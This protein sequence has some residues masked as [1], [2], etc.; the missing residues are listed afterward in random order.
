MDSENIK[1]RV[2]KL[3]NYLHEVLTNVC[4]AYSTHMYQSVKDKKDLLLSVLEHASEME[5]EEIL[6]LLEDYYYL[7][8]DYY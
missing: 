6:Y 2:D 1:H 8:E 5:L 3:N 7:L 4:P